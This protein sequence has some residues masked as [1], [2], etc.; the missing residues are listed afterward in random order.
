M[1]KVDGKGWT[2]VSCG[3]TDQKINIKKH[4]EGHH[5]KRED[6]YCNFCGKHCRSRNA[7]QKHVSMSHRELNL[8]PNFSALDTPCS[9]INTE[10]IQ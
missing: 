6:H 4:I 1:E 9:S 7:L 10:F 3:K 2:C 8:K 5:V